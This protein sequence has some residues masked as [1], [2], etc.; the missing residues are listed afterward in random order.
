M[1]GSRQNSRLCNASGGL[2]DP[3][4]QRRQL[5]SSQVGP[6]R[7]ENCGD[8][9]VTA[10]FESPEHAHQDRLC[11]GSL[12]AAIGVTVLPHAHGWPNL[13]FP[14]AVAIHSVCRPVANS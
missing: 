6:Y 3:P 2:G 10:L 7:I 4:R 11:L 12:L 1:A 14:P 9:I 8:R 13:S 5:T